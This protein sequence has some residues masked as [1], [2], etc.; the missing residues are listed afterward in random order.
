LT[1]ILIDDD[2]LLRSYKPEDAPELFRCISQS[3][4]HL[5]TYLAWVDGT[6]RQ[7]HS[8]QFIQDAIAQQVSG[9]GLALGIFL[10]QD[11]KLIGGIGMHKWNHDLKLA[12]VGYW[13]IKEY[14]GKGL[15]HRSAIRFLDFL[16]HK[17]GLNKVE[18]HIAPP[19]NRS[20]ALAQHLGA[21]TEGVIRQSLRLGGRLE[22]VV[23]TGILYTE[24]DKMHP[25]KPKAATEE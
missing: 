18:M 24:W 19:N 5:R 3:R 25:V 1:S 2:L 22:D 11:R 6:T 4:E 21:K 15:M 16:F 12:H 7:E 14:E 20:I 9:Q 8:L 17:I 13:I 23:I 10:Q